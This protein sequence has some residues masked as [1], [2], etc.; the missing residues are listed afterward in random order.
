[1]ADVV[2]DTVINMNCHT[3]AFS[4]FNLVNILLYWR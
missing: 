2:S 1:M 3:Y 4:V